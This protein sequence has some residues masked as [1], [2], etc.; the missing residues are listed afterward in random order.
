MKHLPVALNLTDKNCLV[1]GGGKVAARKV[2]ALLECDAYVLVVSPR[3]CER[4]QE[5]LPHI[6]YEARLFDAMMAHFPDDRHAAIAAAYDFSGAQLIADIGGGDGATLRH[7][8]TRFSTPSGLLFEREDVIRS[9]SHDK[10]LGG[11]ISLAGGSFF[12]NIP[13]GADIYMLTRVLHNWPDADC[14]RILRVCRAAMERDALLLLGEQILEPDPAD[15][16]PTDYLLDVQMMVMFGSA[17]TRTESEFTSL[18][19]DSGFVMRRI[20]PTSSPVSLVE[21]APV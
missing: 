10:L 2:E 20:V 21:A 11:R 19:A 6:A 7:I 5:L 12:E 15:G 9:N 16:R 3:L 13:R 17:R 14:L 4:M 1:V 18:L 8:L